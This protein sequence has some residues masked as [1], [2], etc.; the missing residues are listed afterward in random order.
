MAERGAVV[1]TGASTGIGRATALHL[2]GR[3]F[4]VFAGVRRQED[5]DALR[6]AGSERLRTLT[7]DVT[8]AASV[9]AAAEEVAGALNGSGLAGLVNNAGVVV[10]GP[11]EFLSL[12]ELRRQLDVNLVGQVAVTQQLLGQLRAGRGRIVNV[13]SIGGRVAPPFIG[14]Y[15]ASKAALA[16]LSDAWRRELRPWGIWVTAVEPGA[17]ATEIWG[18]GEQ[19]ASERMGIATPE[20]REL[21]GE[22]IPR[23][24]EAS[25]KTS[26]MAIPPERV[27]K[28]I[29]R[30]LT[31]R[32][33][34]DRYLV[35]PDARVQAALGLL[36]ARA[37]DGILARFMGL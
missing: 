11:L 21:Y 14:A 10:G 32:R 8:D 5:A 15:T 33:P 22:A 24:L 20:E 1:V 7:L 13:S 37:A 27:A 16:N 28:R 2:D 17:I 12:D 36:P 19:Q 30:A 23:V 18:K 31:A 25:A 3:G 6:A 9:A 34:R 35:G 26:K 4:E 29:E